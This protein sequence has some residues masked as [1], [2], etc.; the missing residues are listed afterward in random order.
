VARNTNR[1][2]DETSPYL[3]HH[4]T[5]PVDWYPW[6]PVALERARNEK[7]PILLSIGY[8]ACHWCHVM[9]RE[10][11]EDEQTARLMNE[12][13][14][15][16][17]VDREER[18]DI[19]HIYMSAVQLLAGRGGWPLTVFL[20]PEGKPFYGGTYFP[21]EDRY[22]TPG[23]RRVLLTV[24]EAFRERPQDIEST[25]G[26]L[27]AHLERS[28][29]CEAEDST[30]GSDLVSD[31]AT[32]L[33]RAYDARYGGL[34][35]APKFPNISVFELFLHTHRNSADADYLDMV[36][37]TLRQM[38]WGGIYDHLG[39]GFHRYSVDERWLVPHFEKMLY[40]NAQL[41]PLYLSAYQVTGDLFFATVAR[42]T[43]DYVLREMKDP[44]GGFYSTQDADSEGE[45]GKFFVWDESEVRKILGDELADIACRYWDVTDAGNF[46]GHNILHISLDLDKLATMFQRDVGELR[47][48]LGEARARLFAARARRVRPARDEKILTAWN[49]LMI[50]ALAKATEL[51]NEEGDL[52]AA[53]EAAAFV[54]KHLQRGDRLLS[55]YKDGE[56]NLNGYLD[57]YAF[58]VAALLDLFEAVQE[59]AYLDRAIELTETMIAHFWDGDGGGFFFTSDDHEELIVR[60][61]VSFDGSIPSG[62]SVAVRNLLR[63][64]HYTGQA[65]YLEHAEATL[66]LFS[67]SMRE[68]PFP[69]ANMLVALDFYTR[70]PYEIVVVTDPDVPAGKILVEQIRRTYLPNRTLTVVPPG[71]DVRLPSAAEGKG[72]VDGK[73]TVYVCRDMSCSPPVTSW[74]D[75]RPLLSPGEHSR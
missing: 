71:G 74:S 56:A 43:I 58:F 11:F 42:E 50:S 62:N 47:L 63:L 53:R 16:I 12:N 41:V 39:G 27:M 40:D 21:P 13:F 5:N 26:Q 66:R 9:E 68:Q 59:P 19:D 51:F 31:A 54:Q 8:S 70:H 6:G 69:Q 22:G 2:S 45:E 17:K 15:N 48:L 46:E 29:H 32:R 30:P 10:S 52:Q 44:D 20:T 23:F 49:G 65:S 35:G 3:R 64:Y 57:D 24:A 37:H 18:P 61:K 1:L 73:P 25:V 55:T 28:D 34:G 36:T 33:A 4:A 14:I 7:R 75:L 67:G 60:T 72:Q 38:A